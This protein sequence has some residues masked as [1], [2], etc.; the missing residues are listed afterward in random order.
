MCDKDYAETLD[1]YLGEMIDACVTAGF[2]TTFARTS[3]QPRYSLNLD[4]GMRLFNNDLELGSRMVY[5]STGVNEDEAKWIANNVKYVHAFNTP[6]N[7][8]PVMVFDAY[9]SYRINKHMQLDFMVN[10]I[11]DRYYLDP[12]A[13]SLMPAPGRTMKVALTMRY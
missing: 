11:T 10:N 4:T 3:L 6:N 8:N 5:H 1:P 12:L 9:A 7:W 2:P 13:R